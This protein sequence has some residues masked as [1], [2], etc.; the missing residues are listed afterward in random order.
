MPI[1]CQ[2]RPKSVN[3]P[4]MSAKEVA[5]VIKLGKQQVVFCCVNGQDRSK[6]L[7]TRF[8]KSGDNNSP[9]ANP[10]HLP[11]G[12]RIYELINMNNDKVKPRERVHSHISNELCEK[13]MDC[14]LA[15]DQREFFTRLKGTST[16]LVFVFNENELKEMNGLAHMLAAEIR[17]L[18]SNSDVVL[19]SYTQLRRY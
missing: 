11:G 14:Q 7:A 12:L 13:D 4:W 19:C 17:A 5:E 15:R 3:I 18:G 1:G 8:N 10:T 9:I 6:G 2:E 16:L